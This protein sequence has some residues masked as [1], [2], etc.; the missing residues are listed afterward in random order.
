MEAPRTP[1]PGSPSSDFPPLA[2]DEKKANLL[3]FGLEEM[4]DLVA[5]W[6]PF[7]AFAILLLGP[8]FDA[9]AQE[10]AWKPKPAPISTRWAE[11]VS[12]DSVLPEYPR[13]QLRRK[14]WLNLNG[15]WELKEGSPTEPVD[16]EADFPETILVPFPVESSLSGVGRPL[17]RI[18]YRRTFRL[19]ESWS[20]DHRTLLHFGAVDWEATVWVNG[21]KIGRHRGGYDPFTMDITEA[22][23]DQ[24]E[25]QIVVSV[26]DPTDRGDQ[27]RGKQVHVPGGIWYTSTTG[28]WQTVW[29]ESVPD[30][31]IEK[32]RF[33]TDI[34]KSAVRIEMHTKHA[35]PSQIILA[36]IFLEGKLLARSYGGTSG[37]I[38][39]KIPPEERKL[40][41]P[42]SPTLYDVHLTLLENSQVIDQ[43]ESYCGLR[44]IDLVTDENGHVRIRLNGAILFQMGILDQGYWPESG[45][46]PPS[47]LAMR[48]DLETV[49][50][51]GFN[52]VRKHVKVEPRRWYYWCD[53]LGLLVWQDMPNGDNSTPQ[54]KKQFEEELLEMVE[55]LD[56]HP[57]IVTWTLFNEG[58][59]QHETVEYCQQISQIDPSR[60]INNAS[61]WKDRDVGH[62]IDHHHYPSPEAPGADG[63]RACVVGT[64]GGIALN[65]P[66]HLWSEECWG[67]ENASSSA[68]LLQRYEKLVDQ[69]RLMSI[70]K[71]LSAAVYA[72]L[73]DVETE[74]NGLMTYDRDLLKI[75]PEAVHRLH[76]SLI[77]PEGI[78]VE[79]PVEP[80]PDSEPTK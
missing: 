65:A 8:W 73:T 45:Y 34:D 29:L 79:S 27:P 35:R 75:D 4:R 13:P 2:E 52:M 56:H 28:I 9:R 46:T 74:C 31:H 17:D 47:D 36:E 63:K 69:L 26:F 54:S 19:P 37:T 42:D 30:S 64:F 1:C 53:K 12:P 41:S 71:G 39:L 22:L 7:H 76:T 72:Q 18:Q 57:S 6:I 33:D 40:W 68:G 23:T 55:T 49:K 78:A 21:N 15:I 43:V 32:V 66:G 77:A 5:R 80:K 44:N 10:Q 61:G 62:L 38:L 25:Q 20:A 59:G 16:C 70:E 67:Y 3:R 24:P 50:R 11:K 51:L 58:W 48:S 60:L 14:R